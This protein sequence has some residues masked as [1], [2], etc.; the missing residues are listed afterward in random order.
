MAA[1][2]SV[3]DENDVFRVAEPAF[4]VSGGDKLRRSILDVIVPEI[5]NELLLVFVGRYP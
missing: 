3:S 5:G 2:W 1:C 4:G